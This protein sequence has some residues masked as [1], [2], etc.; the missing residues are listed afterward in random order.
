MPINIAINGFGRIGRQVYKVIA[1]KH[2]NINVVAVNDL[3]DAKTLAHLLKYDSSYGIWNKKVSFGKD[4]IKIGSKKILVLSEKEPQKL[5]WRKLKVDVVVE[6]TGRFT[7]KKSAEL[8]L[9]AGA[10]KVIITAP[11]NDDVPIFVL[12][13]NQD[14]IKKSDTIV[15]NASCTTNCIAPIM[16]IMERTIGIEKAMMTT[17]HSYTQ[18]QV[19]Q[20]SP[21]KD[22]RRARSATQ[23]IIPTTTGAAIATSKTVS[24]LEGKF[25]G[26]SVRVPT[27]VVSLADITFLAKKNTTKEE[28]NKILTKATKEKRYKGILDATTEEL[29]SSDFLGN[30]YSSIVDLPLTQV[31]DGNLV[32]VVAW[33]DN[34]WGYSNRVAELVNVIA[35]AK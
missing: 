33:Y 27:P 28:I 30:S 19:L 7:D 5:P 3:G 31:V 25:D 22:L 20:D 10:K 29:V 8:H 6:S 24:S 11:T 23:D 17:T 13:V 34:E 16:E 21:H 12:G 32:K 14:K 9:K 26:L 2:K 35:K 18:D 1:E 15:S 4:Y